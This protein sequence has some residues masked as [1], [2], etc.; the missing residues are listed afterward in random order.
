MVELERDQNRHDVTEHHL[1][2]LVIQW[3]E[4]T[5]DKPADYFRCQPVHRY[6]NDDADQQRQHQRNRRL[7]TLIEGHGLPARVQLAQ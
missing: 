1:E 4:R 2:Y 5:E 3:I 7:K 6:D